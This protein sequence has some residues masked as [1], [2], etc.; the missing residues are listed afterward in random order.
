MATSGLETTFYRPVRNYPVPLP[1]QD[2]P[3]QPPPQ[4]PQKQGGAAALVQL[5]YPLS[6]I[7]M[8][9]IMLSSFAGAGKSNP[10]IIV[11][12]VCIVPLSIGAMFLSNYIQRRAGKQA[13]KAEKQM[14]KGYL[15]N[16]QRRLNEI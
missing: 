10:L 8:T 12:E 1:Q 14:Y 15:E 11:A 13:Y 4:I 5:L 3:L 9:V 16:V 7:L 6:G 2:F